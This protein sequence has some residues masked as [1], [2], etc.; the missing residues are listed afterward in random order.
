LTRFR[1][2]SFL[3]ATVL[4]LHAL[5]V[6]RAEAQEVVYVGRTGQLS[7]RVPR[8]EG[9]AAIDGLLSEAQWSTAALLTGFSAY[10]PFDNRP[11]ADSTEVRIWYTERDLFFGVRAWEPH[12]KVHATLAARDRID[13][14]DYVQ[15]LLD[16]FN[17]RRRAFVFGVNP[18][19][20]QSDGIRTDGGGPPQP[21]GTTFGGSPPASIDLNPDFQYESKGHLTDFGYEIE[22]R[23]P[24]KS[25]RFQG[26]NEQTWSFQVLR[27]VQH[28]GYQQTWTPARR[29]SNSFLS[30]SGTLTGFYDLRH[31]QVVELNPELTGSLS[32]A[33][34]SDVDSSWRYTSDPALG[35]NVRWRIVPNITLNGAIR[36]DFSQV[37]ADAAQIPGDTRFSLFFPEKRPFFVDGI[38]QYETPNNLIYT[39]QIVQPEAAVKLGGKIGRTNFA[40]LS[41]VDNTAASLSGTDHP[42]FNILRMRR[43][44]SGSSTAG[45]T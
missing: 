21:R 27:F 37:E 44:L 12:G 30:Q 39:R 40:L 34:R 45:L 9:E 41:A 13:S 5:G 6:P 35:G 20:V 28:S 17:D 4:L 29:G 38:E 19:G 36:P 26:T 18:L 43:D 1:T 15:L 33:P 31:D 14:D 11:A 3:G 7:A 25:I 22:V 32:G 8:L 23:V 42:L 24:L 2:V 10:L 16:P